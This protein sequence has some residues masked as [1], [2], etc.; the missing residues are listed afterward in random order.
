MGELACVEHGSR[1]LCFYI[2][3]R[4]CSLHRDKNSETFPEGGELCLGKYGSINVPAQSEDSQGTPYMHILP[5]TDEM[6][7]R[8]PLLTGRLEGFSM[9]KVSILYLHFAMF[10]TMIMAP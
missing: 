5:C 1:P 8:F 2:V 4:H 6:K 3:T 9:F 10:T 7:G